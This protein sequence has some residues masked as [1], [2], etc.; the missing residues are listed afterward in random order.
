MPGI[1]VT[2]Q[3]GI[4]NAMISSEL[5]KLSD[6]AP[7]PVFHVRVKTWVRGLQTVSFY[8]FGQGVKKPSIIVQ[9]VWLLRLHK[10]REVMFQSLFH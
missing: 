7:I 9:T 10:G 8:R 5:S 4:T 2:L 1:V 6:G 3:G